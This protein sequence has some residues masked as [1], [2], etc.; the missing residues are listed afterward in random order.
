MNEKFKEKFNR[1]W[2]YFEYFF[3]FAF[4][5][6]SRQAIGRLEDDPQIIQYDSVRERGNKGTEKIR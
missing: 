1:T 5:I 2:F 6:I 4:F 3:D